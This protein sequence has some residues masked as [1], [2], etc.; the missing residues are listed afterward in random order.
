MSIQKQ[1]IRAAAARG[2]T[3]ST[4]EVLLLEAFWADCANE[5][6]ADG[7]PVPPIES[8]FH[9]NS[10]AEILTIVGRSKF[11]KRRG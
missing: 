4:R 8:V 5:A 7:E 11:S 1:I 9:D 6:R 10:D 3:L 2:L